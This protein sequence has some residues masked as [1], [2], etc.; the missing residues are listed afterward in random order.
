LVEL[1]CKHWSSCGWQK[2]T[3]SNE[4]TLNSNKNKSVAIAVVDLRLSEGIS[5]LVSQSVSQS[6]ENS[7][8]KK[9]LNFKSYW[10]NSS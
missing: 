10:W 5:W 7:V 2:G 3:S 9:F 8:D 1:C 6:V 4:A